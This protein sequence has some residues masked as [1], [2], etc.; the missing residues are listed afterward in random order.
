VGDYKS[1]AI[2]L[3]SGPGDASQR[4]QV[5]SIIMESLKPFTLTILDT[6]SIALSA[7]VII[8]VE[9]GLDAAHALAIESDIQEA[10]KPKSFDVALELI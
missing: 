2:I 10:L 1:K 9:I 7:R 8:G 3:A 6:Q 5:L 4:D